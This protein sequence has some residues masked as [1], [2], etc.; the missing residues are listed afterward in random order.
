MTFQNRRWLIATLSIAAFGI[1]DSDVWAENAKAANANAHG[2]LPS[3]WVGSEP[4][5]TPP[6]AA[7]SASRLPPVAP[8][9]FQDEITLTPV[10]RVSASAAA[11]GAPPESYDAAPC[12]DYTGCKCCEPIWIHRSGVSRMPCF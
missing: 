2:I 9:S 12:S 6:I 7:A 1:V 10:V 11:T 3:Y 4:K 5:S 8:V